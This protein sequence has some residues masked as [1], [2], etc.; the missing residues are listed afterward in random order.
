MQV[1][2]D[3]LAHPIHGRPS[4]IRYCASRLPQRQF[5]DAIRHV[6]LVDRLE[7]QPAR[8]RHHRQPTHLPRHHVGEAVELSRPQ[9]R[10]RHTRL[11]DGLLGTELLP[12]VSDRHFVRP[13]HGDVH[14]M[15]YSGRRSGSRQV[16]G[17]DRIALGATGQVHHDVDAV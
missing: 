13:D 16:P 2:V 17:G 10:P 3:E 8:Y 7:P 5:H 14:E 11:A 4:K 12:E 1:A 6:P 9:D 15:P